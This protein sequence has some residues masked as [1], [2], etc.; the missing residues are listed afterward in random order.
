MDMQGSR[1]L[2]VSQHIAWDALNDPDVLKACIPGCTKVEAS[3]ENAFD[4][5][6]ALKIGPVSAK[7]TGTIQLTDIEAPN[8]YKLQFEGQGG[9]AGFG[10]GSSHVT[11]TPSGTG[12]LLSYTVN[13][14]VGGK[15]AQLGQRLIDGVASKM[16]DDFFKRFEA[17]LE[18]HHGASHGEAAA[19]DG[20]TP[21]AKPAASQAHSEETADA[22]K[23]INWMI[24]V[25]A[26][27]LIAYW[28]LSGSQ[29]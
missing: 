17:Y 9:P 1:E 18:E 12:T 21:P 4:M 19:Q 16:A 25:G 22:S 29:S 24:A 14:S 28:L 10:K 8:G 6:M 23:R 2:S 11:L 27:G 15:V 26:V 3:G 20:G 5:A 13:A 7:F